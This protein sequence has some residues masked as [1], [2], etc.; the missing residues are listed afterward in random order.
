MSS[1]PAPLQ[2]LGERTRLIVLM[3]SIVAHKRMSLVNGMRRI[4][5]CVPRTFTLT[6]INF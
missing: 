6:G 4:S 1:S 3:R 2:S 5:P